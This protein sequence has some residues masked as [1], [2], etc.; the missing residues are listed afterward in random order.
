M[1]NESTPARV[2]LRLESWGAGGSS[3]VSRAAKA[4]WRRCRRWYT[5]HGQLHQGAWRL[6]SA[7]SP[8][9]N[10]PEE[11][12]APQKNQTL[13]TILPCNCPSSLKF[14]S[15]LFFFVVQVSFVWRCELRGGV[16]ERNRRC[17]AFACVFF[18][19]YFFSLLHELNYEMA[20]GKVLVGWRVGKG[21]ERE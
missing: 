3:P 4:S 19:F 12:Q 20:K 1:R 8:W 2:V 16:K 10:P 14:L 11:T 5:W 13:F 7:S 6:I 21:N 15:S 9:K 17:L 18:I